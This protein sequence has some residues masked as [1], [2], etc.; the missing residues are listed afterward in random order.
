MLFWQ[1]FRKG[2][3]ARARGAFKNPSQNFKKNVYGFYEL[4]VMLVDKIGETP[5]LKFQPG[6]MSVP[7]C[8]ERAVSFLDSPHMGI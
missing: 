4:L 6:K 1:F 8:F 5:F 7:P 3:D 2:R